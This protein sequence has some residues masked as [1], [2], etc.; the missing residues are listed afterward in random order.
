MT[1][2]P[3]IPFNLGAAGDD[4]YEALIAAHRGL[5]EADS[6]RLNARLV[7]ILMNRVGDAAAIGDAIREARRGLG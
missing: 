7:L 2:V 4:V 1:D 3:S 6:Q 5:S